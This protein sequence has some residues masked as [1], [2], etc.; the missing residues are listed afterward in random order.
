MLATGVTAATE[1]RRPRVRAPELRGRGWLNTDRDLTPRRP[2]WAVRAARLLGVLLHQLPAR[3][4]RAAAG[5]GEVRRRARRR[6]R[7]L[8]EVR[9]RGRPG[10][11]AGRGGALP[12]RAP[13]A[14]RPRPGDLAGVHR[15][16][17]AD[18][19]A[20]G[21][22]G[23]RRGAV[24]RRG[25]RARHRRA[26]R[27]APPVVR[28][29]GNPPAGR[30]ALRRTGAAV[31]RPAL[32]GEGRPP[33][34]RDV[35]GRRRRSPLPGRARRGRRDRRAPH[36][37]R[38]ARPRRRRARPGSTSPTACACC[39]S[40]VAAEVGYDVVVAD[41]VN[42]ALRG[43][44]LA[45]GE[46]TTLAGDGRQLMQ[47]DREPG[48]LSSPWDV[49]WWGDRVWVAMAGVHQLWTFDPRTGVA[50]AGRRHDERGSARRAARAGVVRADV[51]PGRGRRPALAR[52]QRD[53]ERAVRRGRRRAHGRR[54]RA[55]RL[56]LPGRRGRAGAAP[57]PARRDRAARRVGGRVRHLQR[58]RTSD[59]ATAP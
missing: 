41:T 7:A 28:R 25:P 9:A 51:R 56:R 21:P 53:L 35:P 20:R 48:A 42:H 10:G 40:D 19:R 16:G 17:L 47:G 50:D 44:A 45:T 12:G 33:P 57:A 54:H 39:P 2:A 52:G 22:G 23:V 29:P 30:L 31:R 38:R 18:A 14:R 37:H 59:R 58:R 46:V 1:G 26:A 34:G 32:P 15:P 43:V 36:R 13:G 3:P 49:T 24:R 55:V 27:R 5:R 8:A 11:A 4:R 6:G